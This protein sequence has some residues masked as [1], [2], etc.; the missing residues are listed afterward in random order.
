[1]ND[2]ERKY[3]AA[4]IRVAV[5]AMRGLLKDGKFA[6]QNDALVELTENFG[7]QLAIAFEKKREGELVNRWTEGVP[8]FRENLFAAD[9][10]AN[11]RAAVEGRMPII[12]LSAVKD[13]EGRCP[14]P[15]DFATYQ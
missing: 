12:S 2:E 3:I 4:V 10:S 11:V 5:S 8:T 1:M 14:P 9:Q 13:A 15:P 7:G 6:I